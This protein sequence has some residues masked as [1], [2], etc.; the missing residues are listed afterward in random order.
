M[1]IKGNC[2][3]GSRQRKVGDFG[4]RLYSEEHERKRLELNNVQLRGFED[5]KVGDVLYYNIFMTS[6][7]WQAIKHILCLFYKEAFKISY[8]F[9]L[10]GNGKTLCFFSSSYADRKDHYEA[11]M[12]ATGIIKNQ[13]SVKADTS[14]WCFFGLRFLWLLPRWNRKLKRVEADF[15]ARMLYLRI[16]FRAYVDYNYVQNNIRNLHVSP[17]YLIS[18]CDVM[19]V[20]SYL[21]QKFN[22]QECKT[23][24]LQHGM[25]S[26]IFNPWT[27]RGTK[28]NYFLAQCQQ[29]IE[30]LEK[31]G[32]F[33]KAIAVGSPHQFNMPE[34]VCNGNYRTENLGIFMNGGD[35]GELGEQNKEMIRIVQKYCEQYNKKLMIKYHPANNPKFYGKLINQ[36]IVINTFQKDISVTLF[37]EKIDISISGNSTTFV[38]ALAADKPSLLFCRKDRDV[39]VYRNTD[40]VK[41]STSKELKGIID[42]ISGDFTGQMQELNN[43]F[44][45]K[46]KISDNYKKAYELIGIE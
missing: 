23:V 13:I 7:F 12:N 21:V 3:T 14:I 24:T 22:N 38:T 33:G 28:C 45:V 2:F 18:Y 30:D 46:G 42:K 36:K 27:I 16:L 39:C 41:F 43:Y 11:F 26:L 19:P 31:A 25:F 6:G 17:K 1:K 44:N 8:S 15:G 29:N 4:L 20:D 40:A 10:R 35:E 34:I 37:L 32:F 9:K 5:I